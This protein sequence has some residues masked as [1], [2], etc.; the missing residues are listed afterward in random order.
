M[1]EGDVGVGER[2]INLEGE[3]GEAGCML[4]LGG[5]PIPDAIEQVWFNV[6]AAQLL[7]IRR[8]KV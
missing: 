1:G 5:S 7:S 3:E 4:V 8:R 6:F 2:V